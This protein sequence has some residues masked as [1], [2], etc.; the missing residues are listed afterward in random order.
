MAEGG[1]GGLAPK[2]AVLCSGH[3]ALAGRQSRRCMPGARKGLRLQCPQPLG[4]PACCSPGV[5][6]GRGLKAVAYGA[7]CAS[8]SRLPS[9]RP[10]YWRNLRDRMQRRRQQMCRRSLP[11]PAAPRAT[12]YLPILAATP[13]CSVLRSAQPLAAGQLREHEWA[14]APVPAQG[15]G[16]ER[17]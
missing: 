11:T 4:S 17:A 10:A 1:L 15:N 5:S 9:C 2:P 12:R 14:A 6:P 3:G 16:P 8:R 7:F 13:P